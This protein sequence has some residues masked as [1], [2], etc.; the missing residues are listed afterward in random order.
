M[1]RIPVLINTSAP[2]GSTNPAPVGSRSLAPAQTRT[3]GPAQP[4]V[5]FRDFAQNRTQSAVV[6]SSARAR[7][8]YDSD[9]LVIPQVAFLPE[10][11]TTVLHR[12]GRPY[13]GVNLGNI[14]G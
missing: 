2:V 3:S 11:I 4:R 9:Q 13:I 1:A 5:Q 7:G 12:L 10:V 14:T 8:Q 6:Q